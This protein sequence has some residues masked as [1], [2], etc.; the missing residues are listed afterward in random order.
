M[1]GLQN[2][3]ST[4]IARIS[5]QLQISARFELA[6]LKRLKILNMPPPPFVLHFITFLVRLC[7]S[8]SF[9]VSQKS[10]YYNVF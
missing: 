10:N 2:N 8:Q 4:V 5:A 6:S 9:Q 7:C 1:S 3:E